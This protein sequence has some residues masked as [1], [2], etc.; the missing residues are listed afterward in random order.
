MS[1]DT[2]TIILQTARRLFVAQ[3]YTATSMRQIA[4]ESGIGKATIYHH[5]SDKHALITALAE[6]GMSGMTAAVSAIPTGGDPRQTICRAA[7]ASLGLLLEYADLWQVLRREVPG[8]RDYMQSQLAV[9]FQEYIA[10]IAS[11]VQF[12][13]E[14]G[15]FR[16]MNP[17]QAAHAFLTM[18]Q[19]IFVQTLFSGEKP[20]ADV[21]TNLLD[22]YFHGIEAH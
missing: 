10:M 15:T 3:G 17:V 11:A 14:A 9:F 5:F 4:E 20:S 6:Q 16:A 18:I 13:I 21:I 2:P 7:E 12:G 22:I 8:G 1:T 19:G